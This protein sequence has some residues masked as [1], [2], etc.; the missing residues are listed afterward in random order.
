MPHK[1][2]I[3]AYETGP[4]GFLITTQK[5]LLILLAH[6]THDSRLQL[7]LLKWTAVLLILL[8]A[9]IC[10]FNLLPILLALGAFFPIAGLCTVLLWIGAGD[11]FLKFALEDEGFY[12]LATQSR[13][14]NIFEDIEAQTWRRGG[15]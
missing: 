10:G 7:F 5:A 3:K 15:V 2:F 4:L 9:G 6:K 14:L 1:M 8:S 11:I 12:Q 13:A